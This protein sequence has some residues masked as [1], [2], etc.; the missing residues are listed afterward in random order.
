MSSIKI[1]S[2][3]KWNINVWEGNC[4]SCEEIETVAY[5][6]C[7]NDLGGQIISN[8]S[9]NLNIWNSFIAWNICLA[10][11]IKRR[12]QKPLFKINPRNTLCQ[13]KVLS[14]ANENKCVWRKL[15]YAVNCP[16][17]HYPIMCNFY[18]SL[19]Q[20]IKTSI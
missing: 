6:H 15:I 8:I 5:L 17:V 4:K 11:I 7:C 1:S 3:S 18:P 19:L 10:M 16:F 14:W 13:K 9:Y 2:E 20:H 12:C